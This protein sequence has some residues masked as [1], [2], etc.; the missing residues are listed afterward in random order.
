MLSQNEYV[1]STE[2]V[3]ASVAEGDGERGKLFNIQATFMGIY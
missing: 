2:V 3:Y 1:E